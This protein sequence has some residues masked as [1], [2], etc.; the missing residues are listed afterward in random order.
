MDN[1]NQHFT[2][3]PKFSKIMVA[4]DGSEHS[5]KAAQYALDIAK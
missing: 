2:K 4:I 5:L 1:S 3:D